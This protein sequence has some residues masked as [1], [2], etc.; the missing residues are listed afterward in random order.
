MRAAWLAALAALSATPA[1]AGTVTLTGVMTGAD[2]QTYREV[3]FRVPAGTTAVTV[4]FAYSGKDQKAVIDLGLRDP[5]RFRGWSGGN[6]ARFTVTETWATPSYL[7]G[8]LPAGEWKLILGVPNLRKDA[9]AEYTATITLADSPVFHGFAETPL[10]SGPDWY[11]GDLH[12][13]TGH[14]D[15]SCA[16]RT[17][18]RA[19]CPLFRTL[20]AAAGRGLDFVAVT[21]HNATSHHQALAELQP[22]YG[23]L[24]LIPGREI[25][26]FQ[27]H[28]NV[29]GVTAPLDFQLGGPRAP[30]MA[31]IQAQVEAAQ[32]LLSINHPG[33]P[34]G[35]ACMGC[36]WTAATDFAR[37]QSVEVVNGGI[38]MGPL[39]GIPFWEARLN[40]GLRITAIGGS[41]NHDPALTGDRALGV[42]TTVVHA[43]N[44]GQDAILASLRAGHAFIDVQ[45]SR[46]RLL[47]MTAET[48]AA[49][50][51]M[52]DVLKLPP[53][54]D[55]RLRVRVKGAA[56]GSL[57]FRADPGT[58]PLDPRPI[59]SQDEIVDLAIAGA[60]GRHWLRAEVR[61]AD[62]R[63]W[64]I[65]NPIYLDGS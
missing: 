50:A 8:P 24:L 40:A 17:G 15:G 2:H 51:R 13:H 41:D 4:E 29:F 34:S 16:G 3:P 44:L 20:E 27:G 65:G 26:T 61:G 55:A 22:F 7:P 5:Q 9:R 45:G 59:A 57:S 6:K 35:E 1:F 21:E 47:D 53:G 28:A 30:D 11:R 56:G 52:G 63:L 37:I 14:S 43:D 31:R 38:A 48:D 23:D 12:L 58:K 64:L 49:T 33:L 32:G 54:Q 60:A 46:D 10:K 42:P 18:A 36:G 39:S 25:T 62:G 19:P